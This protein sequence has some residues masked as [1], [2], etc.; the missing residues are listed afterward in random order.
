MRVPAI[1]TGTPLAWAARAQSAAAPTPQ[2]PS[3]QVHLSGQTAAPRVDLPRLKR[4][5]LYGAACATI[6]F[7]VGPVAAGV[8]WVLE[9]RG[10][11]LQD[12]VS[13]PPPNKFDD[14]PSS[15]VERPVMFVHGW[16]SELEFYDDLTGKLTE[17]GANGGRVGYVQDGKLF[18]DA[19]CTQKLAN[20]TADMKVFLSVFKSNR[21]DPS[22]T[23]PELRNNIELV[24]KLTG[25]EKV[26]VAS[27]SMGGLA[28]RQLAA[29]HPDDHHVGKFLMLGT[30]NQGAGLAGLVARGLEMER[31]GWNVRWLLAWQN[32]T[33]QDTGAVEYLRPTSPEREALNTRWP[34]QQATFE[35]TLHLGSKS[36]LTPSKLLLPM[37]GDGTV[38]E[39]SLHLPGLE[40]RHLETAGRYGNHAN[41]LHNPDTYLQSREFFGWK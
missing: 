26:D 30:P 24:R 3:D 39:K 40:V 15:K 27:Y 28:T 17:G 12:R 35:A 14:L 1:L 23:A 31:E 9:K 4:N 25:S 22:V 13:E 10:M 16:H 34:A 33:Q 36:R 7:I 29:D 18:A 11:A 21:S 2:A 8:G 5:A 6:N 38:T 20:P 41:L 32:M 19:E 37:W